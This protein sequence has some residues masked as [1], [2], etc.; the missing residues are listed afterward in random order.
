MVGHVDDK[1]AQS[2]LCWL[3]GETV[4]VT[5]GEKGLEMR[6]V[7]RMGGAIKG[8]PK[9]TCTLLTKVGGGPGHP[10]RLPG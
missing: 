9:G 3:V 5:K 7:G 6:M 4:Q 1:I 2:F 10:N 8:K